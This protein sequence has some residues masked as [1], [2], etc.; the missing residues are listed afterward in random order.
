MNV[1]Q[2][3]DNHLLVHL[4]LARCQLTTVNNFSFPNLNSLDLTDNLVTE[5]SGHHFVLM[6]QLTVLF[7]AGN[8]L[9]SVFADP[10]GVELKKINTLDLSRVKTHSVD[11]S[12][13]VVLSSLHTLNLSHSDVD[14]L[15][16]NSSRMPDTPLQNLDLRG[17]TARPFK[18]DVLRSFLH[19]QVLLTDDFRLCCRSVLPSGFDLNQCHT[20][21]DDVS[22]CNNL[23]GSVTYRTTVAVLATL[24]LLGNVLSL[25]LRVCLSSSWRLSAHG[26]LLTQLSVADLCTGLYLAIMG[27]AD[28]LLAGDY[29]WRDNTW[30]RGAVCHLAGVLAVCCR[31]A[32]T[33][34]ITVLCLDR[35]L[36]CSPTF[37]PRL[38]LTKVKVICAGVWLSALFLSVVPLTSQWRTFGK[39]ALCVPLPHKRNGTVES[40]YVFGV[41]VLLHFIMFVLSSFYEAINSLLSRKKIPSIMDK[42]HFPKDSQFVVLGSLACGFL[43]TTACLVPTDSYSDRQKATHTAL[44]FFS[45][46][47]SCSLNPC[48]HLYGVRVERNKRIKEERLMRIVKRTS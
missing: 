4:G 33:F 13:F 34:S 47:A 30:R 25:I 41:Q 10:V 15:P 43:F 40:Y 1:S 19:L 42:A 24:A 37:I 45:S 6:P 18:G 9:T 36:H 32:T 38:N 16:W 8:P 3:H 35:C 2:L 7:L 22:S 29:V 14:L 46:V 27:L 31:H 48:L 12:V 5:V 44:V 26:V 11:H 39:Q 28:H 20:T 17:L 21:P 23:L